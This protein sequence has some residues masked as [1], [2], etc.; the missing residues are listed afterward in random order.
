M[1]AKTALL[2]MFGIYVLQWLLAQF[3]D[4]YGIF[5]WFDMPMHLAGG[6]A[7]GMLGVAL[8]HNITDKHHTESA[9]FWYHIL[10]VVGFTCL[11]AVAWEFHEY[12]IDN[13]I[14]LWY[15]WPKY[16]LSLTDTMSDLALGAL[17]GLLAAYVFR[18]EW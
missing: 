17:G 11:I 12:L 1:S 4:V 14:G 9:P 8:H 16:Q 13:T 18:K 7:A 10:F 3:F 15:K 6:F 5:P 2:T